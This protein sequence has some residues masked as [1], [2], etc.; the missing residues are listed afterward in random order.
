VWN[1]ESL[2][3]YYNVEKNWRGVYN[4]KEEFTALINCWEKWEPKDKSKKDTIRTVWR[5]PDGRESEGESLQEK[6]QW[7]E[8]EGEGYGESNKTQRSHG[9]KREG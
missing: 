7:W 3:F 9:K 6:K 4:S 5:T 8:K 1:R 2:E